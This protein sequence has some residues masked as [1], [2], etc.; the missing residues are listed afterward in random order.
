[1]IKHRETPGEWKNDPLQPRS[2]ITEGGITEVDYSVCC[3]S[4][5]WGRMAPAGSSTSLQSYG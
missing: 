3:G 2:V 1:M 4:K 5:R